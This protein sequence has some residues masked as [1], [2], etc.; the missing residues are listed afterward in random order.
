M[1]HL[2][3]GDPY[4]TRKTRATQYVG[5]IT[6]TLLISY[7]LSMLQALQ[8]LLK[9]RRC[10]SHSNIYE[11]SLT[12]APVSSWHKVIPSFI[13]Y[14]ILELALKVDGVHIHL[15][16]DSSIPSLYGEIRYIAV[17]NIPH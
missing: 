16:P 13:C 2:A 8:D 4:N 15:N 5:R 14:A 17:V 3:P 12:T 1:R 10:N 9:G 11:L 7:N 6:G